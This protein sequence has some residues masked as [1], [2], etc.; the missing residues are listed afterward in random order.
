MRPTGWNTKIAKAA[1]GL[2]LLA[3]IILWASIST[4]GREPESPL[5][6]WAANP[7]RHVNI[8][9]RLSIGSTGGAV[10]Q[11]GLRLGQP[12]F[13]LGNKHEESEYRQRASRQ[14]QAASVSASEGQAAGLATIGSGRAEVAGPSKDAARKSKL[15]QASPRP[16]RNDCGG[17]PKCGSVQPGGVSDNGSPAGELSGAIEN[18]RQCVLRSPSETGIGIVL[19]HP[20]T[21][22]SRKGAKPW[23]LVWTAQRTV[24]GSRIEGYQLGRANWVHTR[25]RTGNETAGSGV[26]PKDRGEAPRKE[27]ISERV[28]PELPTIHWG[29]GNLDSHAQGELALNQPGSPF[30]TLAAPGQGFPGELSVASLFSRPDQAFTPGGA[31]LLL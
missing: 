17:T 14:V 15:A 18:R 25:E 9:D 22:G 3:T 27:D 11:Q 28:L 30:T 8:E 6:D 4:F 12:V 21:L 31:F 1:K 29:S 19:A 26:V 10:T 5:F 13:D 20:Q 24:P 2:F 16:L 23:P 7:G